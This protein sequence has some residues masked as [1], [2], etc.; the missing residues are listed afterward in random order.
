MSNRLLHPEPA[1]GA[2]QKWNLT[3][4]AT[5]RSRFRHAVCLTT[6]NSE[7]EARKTQREFEER[8]HMRNL[9]DVNGNYVSIYEV[10]GEYAVT[11]TYSSFNK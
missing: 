8:K 1:P 6:C 7:E 10:P 5:D 4:L 11:Q 9:R 2:T 3:F